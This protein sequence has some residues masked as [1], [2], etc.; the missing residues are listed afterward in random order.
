MNIAYIQNELQRFAEERDWEQYHTPK[1]LAMA[2]AAEASDVMELFQ[3][4]N[5]K[6]S[7]LM[8]QTPASKQRIEEELADVFLYLIRFADKFDIDLE[9]IARAKLRDNRKKFPVAV[10]RGKAIFPERYLKEEVS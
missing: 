6:E 5:D 2:L 9:K 4:C 3:W 7:Y 10:C 1:N 8:V